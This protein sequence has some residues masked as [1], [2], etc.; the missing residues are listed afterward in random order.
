MNWAKEFDKWLGRA[1][2]P[3]R[4]MVQKGGEEGQRLIRSFVRIKP[5]QSEGMLA[6][7]LSSFFVF[8]R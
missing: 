4:V 5:N 2:Q 1:S 7:F 3:R 6:L 8:F